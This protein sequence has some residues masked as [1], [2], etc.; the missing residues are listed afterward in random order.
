MINDEK[1]KEELENGFKQSLI[2]GV[3]A[4]ARA[5]A[6]R[7]HPPVFT[8]TN[9]GY[10]VLHEEVKEAMREIESVEMLEQTIDNLVIARDII[11]LEK[12]LREMKQKAIR[13]IDELAQVA[14]MTDKFIYSMRQDEK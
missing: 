2:L 7:K 10:G 5:S 6:D 8:D 12:S 3:I 9:H 11:S 1:M 4:S 14:A 13:A